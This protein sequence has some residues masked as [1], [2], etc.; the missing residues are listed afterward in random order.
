M[1]GYLDSCMVNVALNAWQ[2]PQTAMS[3]LTYI[4]YGTCANFSCAW[5]LAR[6]FILRG[7]GGVNAQGSE[8]GGSSFVVPSRNRA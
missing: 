3:N 7:P 1:L 4:M 2:E 8:A 5:Q 6:A